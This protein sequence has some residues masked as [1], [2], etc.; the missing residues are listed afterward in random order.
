MENGQAHTH[1]HGVRPLVSPLTA[2]LAFAGGDFPAAAENM[3]RLACEI[4]GMS[5]L[6]LE[7]ARSLIED[8]RDAR[9]MDDLVAIQAKYVTAMFQT[10]ADGSR[11]MSSLLADL[12]R[13]MTQASRDMLEASVQAAQNV[14]DVAAT[15]LAAANADEFT[16]IGHKQR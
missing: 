11:R 16:P 4:A 12:P 15:T 6:S 9:Q 2:Q 13:D 8:M 1:N 7:Q 5:V 10:F 14:A 3:R